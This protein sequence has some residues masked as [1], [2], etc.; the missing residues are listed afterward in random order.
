MFIAMNRFQVK[1]ECTADFEALWRDREV[2]IDK[3]PG[4]D[5]KS[6]V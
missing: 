3:L 1:K 2:H 5:R 6:V 4:L